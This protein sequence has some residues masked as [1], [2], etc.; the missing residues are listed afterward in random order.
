MLKSR[1]SG[2][3]S[4]GKRG[5]DQGKNIN[6]TLLHVS[7]GLNSLKG[8]Y[9]GDYM[10]TTI[11]VTKGDAGSLDYSECEFLWSTSVHFDYTMPCSL[12]S[13]TLRTFFTEVYNSF[14]K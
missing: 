6:P 1:L 5:R 9:T 4:I 12:F 8:G 14:P 3:I 10:G 13:R 7:Y 11:E 2:C